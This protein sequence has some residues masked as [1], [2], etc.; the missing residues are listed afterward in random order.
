MDAPDRLGVPSRA[1]RREISERYYRDD[2]GRFLGPPSA[3]AAWSRAFLDP[4][5]RPVRLLELGCGPGRD[6]RALA[7]PRVF[8]RAID[9]APTAIARARA[10]PDPPP[11]LVL[12][13]AEALDVLRSSPAGSLDAVYAHA[14]Y[15]FLG[16]EEVEAMVRE[17]ARSLRVGGVHLFSVRS[18]ASPLA[19]QGIEL[20]P[21]VRLRADREEAVRFYRASTLG[22]ITDGLERVR[23]EERTDE[24]AWYVC[25]RRP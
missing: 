9:H 22:R 25:D 23:A 7:G 17:I 8:V 20:A 13:E 24:C 18:T 11:T 5:P 19:R 21:D 15:M 16:D 12:E 2:P 3:F 10:Q 6:A 1:R 14:L 4:L